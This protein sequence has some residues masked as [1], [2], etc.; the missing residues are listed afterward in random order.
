MVRKHELSRKQ[1]TA[2]CALVAL[3]THHDAAK[4]AGV[5]DRTLARWMHDSHFVGALRTAKTEA[6]NDAILELQAGAL[7]AVR[8]LVLNLE[9]QND[10]ASNAAAIAILSNG[11][12]GREQS[13]IMKRIDDLQEMLESLERKQQHEAQHTGNYRAA[14][15]RFGR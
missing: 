13:E 9:S 5:A 10:F 1:A 8:R 15:A 4:L 3:A 14:G 7:K 11:L 6:F 2:I 12:K